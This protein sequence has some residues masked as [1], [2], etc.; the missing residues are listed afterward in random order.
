MPVSN[1]L[2]GRSGSVLFDAASAASSWLPRPCRSCARFR[3]TL[4][5]P[6]PPDQPFPALAPGPQPA[7]AAPPSRAAA[8]CAAPAQ[9]R[10]QGSQRARTR[11]RAARAWLRWRPPKNAVPILAKPPAGCAAS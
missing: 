9:R 10:R 7:Q 8:A 3:V 1:G 5:S 6:R 4:R 2:A 11:A